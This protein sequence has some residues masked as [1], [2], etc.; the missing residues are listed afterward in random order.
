MMKTENYE[1]LGLYMA[2]DKNT[3]LCDKTQ[4]TF[5]CARSKDQ[6]LSQYNKASVALPGGT[7]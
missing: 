6:V 3:N 2:N 1:K 4:F 7:L 5:V